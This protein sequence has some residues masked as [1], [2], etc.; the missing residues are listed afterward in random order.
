MGT[1]RAA[2]PDRRLPL[3]SGST[4]SKARDADRDLYR[5]Y[6]RQS[7]ALRRRSQ[8]LTANLAVTQRER[9]EDRAVLQ[10]GLLAPLPST[11]A[12]RII[13][14]ALRATPARLPV[15]CVVGTSEGPQR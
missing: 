6:A 10:R 9:S 15:A 5:R 8:E 1:G 4:P 13:A 11:V 12:Y 3:L 14:G 2:T 7:P